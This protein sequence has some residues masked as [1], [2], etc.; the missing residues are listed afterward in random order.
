MKWN[1]TVATAGQESSVPI[2][3]KYAYSKE[4]GKF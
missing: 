4:K 1:T 2:A 3:D